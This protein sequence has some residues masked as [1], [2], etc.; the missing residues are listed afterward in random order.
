M[1]SSTSEHLPTATHQ[2]M[3]CLNLCSDNSQ[4]YL[5]LTAS[6]LATRPPTASPGK[7]LRGREDE[8]DENQDQCVQ[9]SPVL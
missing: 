8:E 1:F 3:E 9:L 4:L 7:H 5:P 6:L 2:S